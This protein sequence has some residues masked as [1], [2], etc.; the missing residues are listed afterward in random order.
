MN[1][2]D[3]GSA[4]AH[5]QA[6]IEQ[7]GHADAIAFARKSIDH[8]TNVALRIDARD[9]A[10]ASTFEWADRLRLL[11]ADVAKLINLEAQSDEE[12]DD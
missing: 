3:L 1:I 11:W 10:Q 5:A 4:D 7:M 9:P 6:L 2:T 8:Y 12:A